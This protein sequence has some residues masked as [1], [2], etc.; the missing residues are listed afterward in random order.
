[1]TYANVIATLAL[2]IALG[3]SSYA[4]LKLPKNAVGAAQLR[5]GSVGASEVK[6]RSLG[7]GEFKSSARAGLR[8]AQ[9]A[10]GPQGLQGLQGPKGDAGAPATRLWASVANGAS[11]S[12]LFGSGVTAV[13]PAG[14]SGQVVVTF[15]RDVSQCSFQATVLGH[16][17]GSLNPVVTAAIT[18]GFYAG[19]GL[20]NSQIQVQTYA[21][22]VR[23]PRDFDVAAFC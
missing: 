14:F 13:G 16:G 3:G 17:G 2:F 23:T 21:D 18:T 22:A 8:G 20:T 9:G 6:N 7:L 4:A 1:L 12:I 11:P 5:T 15:D 19:S 10:Q